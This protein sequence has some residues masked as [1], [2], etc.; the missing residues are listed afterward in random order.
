MVSILPLLDPA[1]VDGLCC[2]VSLRVVE[3]LELLE[4]CDT[5]SGAS[6]K[7]VDELVLFSVLRTGLLLLG[8]TMGRALTA[9]A[10]VAVDVV[11][12]SLLDRL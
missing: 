6:P 3:P 10:A 11:A 2:F 1:R 5:T 9:T 8:A 7:D 4:D 12:N